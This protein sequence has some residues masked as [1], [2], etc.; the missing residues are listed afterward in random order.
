[1][2]AQPREPML[3][4]AALRERGWTPGLIN[5]FLGEPDAL[6]RNPHYAKAAPMRLYALARVE[7][8]ERSAGFVTARAGSA[9]RVNG[10][11]KAVE[12]KRESLLRQVAEMQVSVQVQPVAMVLHLAIEAYNDRLLH[13]ERFEVEPASETSD[14]AFLERITVNF[15][16]HQLTTYDE[17][18]EEVAGRV[19]VQDAVRAI[20]RK[21]FATITAAYPD[22][23][24]E[25]YRQMSR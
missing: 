8:A 5:T 22:L 10:A 24:Q 9:R 15:I 12:T 16:R 20:R 23:E 14:P 21:V 11:K 3:S 18:L 1:M 13:T 17:K 19:G 6:K 4:S 7:A 2:G 25:C